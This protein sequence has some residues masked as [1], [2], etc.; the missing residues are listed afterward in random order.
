MTT[1]VRP[2]DQGRL[3]LAVRPLTPQERDQAGV[4]G[5]LLVEDA[6]GTGR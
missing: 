1:A 3:G 2:R 4:P 5:G 6:R